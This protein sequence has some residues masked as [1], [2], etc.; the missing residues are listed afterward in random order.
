MAQEQKISASAKYRQRLIW[1]SE[2]YFK[3][4]VATV[5]CDHPECRSWRCQKPGTWCYGFNVTVRPGW[6]Y[7][8]GDI[9]FLALSRE[10]DMIAWL[11]GAIRDP[12]YMA[13]KVPQELVVQ[14]Y[15]RELGVEYFEELQERV[16]ADNLMEDKSYEEILEIFEPW[17]GAA[18]SDEHEFQQAIHETYSY[19]LDDEPRRCYDLTPSFICQWQALKWW[20]EQLDAAP[21]HGAD[22]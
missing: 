22:T 21:P 20:L 13:Q 17:I 16:L 12:D 8:D 4:H 5:T 3:D 9:G 14:E 6:I 18:G 7:L 19:E 2:Q 11:R 15:N 10:R 1:Q